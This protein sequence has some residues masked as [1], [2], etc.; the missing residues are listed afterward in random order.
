MA[1]YPEGK[2]A[3][4]ELRTDRIWLRPL[5]TTDVDM[6]YDA[7]MASAEMLHLW[8][9]HDWPS[10][11]FTLAGNLADL[12]W[13]E[14]EHKERTAFTYTVVDPAGTRCLGCVYIVPLW[15]GERALGEGAA[16]PADVAFWVRASE[17]AAGLDAHLLATLRDW[18]AKAWAF[19]RVVYRVSAQYAHHAGLFEAAGLSRRLNF[20]A[21]D[22]AR[23]FVFG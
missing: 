10:E 19:D 2:T 12:E 4:E 23:W 18:F 5:R 15:E 17:V 9:Q 13:H 21:K 7:V 3:P 14:M 22:G 6:D 11:G 8:G 20:V 1:F 16:Y